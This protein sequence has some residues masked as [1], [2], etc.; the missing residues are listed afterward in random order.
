M[1]L[2][3]LN[4]DI[5]RNT[6]VSKDIYDDII[7]GTNMISGHEFRSII[8]TISQLCSDVV[9]KTLGPYGATTLLDDG[10]GFVYPTKDGWSALNRLKFNDPIYN[11]A[12]NVLRQTSF[13]AVT[14]V[15]DGTTTAMVVANQFLQTMLD[16]ELDKE[17]D[18]NQALFRQAVEEAQ[19][20][21]ISRLK[22][23]MVTPIPHNEEGYDII[24]RIAT[25]ATNGNTTFGNMIADIY[26]KTQN[27]NIHIKIG[28]DDETTYEIE[29]GYKMEVNPFVLKAYVNTDDQKAILRDWHVVVFDHN[30]TYTTHGTVIAKIANTMMANGLKCII[31]APYFDRILTDWMA[32]MI[33]RA[34]HE[35][36]LPGLMFCQIPAT[37]KLQKMAISDLATLTGAEVIDDS[38]LSILD[39]ICIQENNGELSPKQK[40]LLEWRKAYAKDEPMSSDMFVINAS[41]KIVTGEFSAN[42][43][44]LRDYENVMNKTEWQNAKAEAKATWE[45]LSRK[46]NKVVTGNLSKEYIDAHQRYIRLVGKMGI[47]KVGGVSELQRICDKDSIADACLACRSAWEH[48]WVRGMCLDTLSIVDTLYCEK[49]ATAYDTN[50]P[51][52]VSEID[53]YTICAMYAIREA[54]TAAAKA[55]LQNKCSDGI[56]QRVCSDHSTF[57]M[58]NEAIIG[59]LIVGRESYDVRTNTFWPNDSENAIINSVETDIQILRATISVLTMVVTSTQYISMARMYDRKMTKQQAEDDLQNKKFLEG[60]S[61]GAGVIAAITQEDSKVGKIV[62]NLFKTC[63]DCINQNK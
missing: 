43:V 55:V 37:T 60:K 63:E 34:T 1:N 18:F 59:R 19:N 14:S 57:S 52:T 42:E 21:V 38:K 36:L 29:N 58:T 27:P 35:N 25:I 51:N 2:S 31:V 26:E 4:G 16:L 50:N 3:K 20:E 40:D 33:E 11:T 30:M 22:D 39:A 15:G 49:L 47:I 45:E 48:G 13:N 28:S 44:Y 17:P 5:K 32:Q 7:S 12:L 9:V 56:L 61:F 24:R 10:N 6:N 41:G 62:E 46:A 8:C 23:E 53:K 54:F